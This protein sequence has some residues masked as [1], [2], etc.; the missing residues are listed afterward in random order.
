MVREKGTCVL[1]TVLEGCAA[2]FGVCTPSLNLFR[3]CLDIHPARPGIRSKPE[4]LAGSC[5]ERVGG[6]AGWCFRRSRITSH[7]VNRPTNH[8]VS[9]SLRRHLAPHIR[10]SDLPTTHKKRGNTM[11]SLAR[12]TILAKQPTR[13]FQIFFFFVENW[14]VAREGKRN[15]RASRWLGRQLSLSRQGTRRDS[16]NR[17]HHRLAPVPC[18]P[19]TSLGHEVSY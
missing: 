5:E 12:L 16:S 11:T 19:W 2:R 10:T 6:F 13:S 4:I 9:S 1:C 17:K 14:R 7:N 3:M 18:A 15:A 8:F